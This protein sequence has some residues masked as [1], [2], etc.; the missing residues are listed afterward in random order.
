M[1]A[2]IERH[3]IIGE[4]S[5]ILFRGGGSTGVL[6]IGWA[7]SY[8]RI[9]DL[10]PTVRTLL[11]TILGL[12]LA[13]SA[14]VIT[15]GK[16]S[17]DTAAGRST[18]RSFRSVNENETGPRDIESAIKIL[19]R[20]RKRNHVPECSYEIDGKETTRWGLCKPS[21]W[22]FLD[23][24]MDPATKQSLKDHIIRRYGFWNPFSP[25][26]FYRPPKWLLVNLFVIKKCYCHF[27]WVPRWFFSCFVL[28]LWKLG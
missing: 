1:A 4:L 10:F 28:L 24:G 22:I 2:S 13:R 18:C 12:H 26:I 6:Y 14:R 21:V 8:Q 5:C 16:L 15:R 27:S 25:Q 23:L 20:R 19:A 9:Y 3:A 7:G 11:G 17:T